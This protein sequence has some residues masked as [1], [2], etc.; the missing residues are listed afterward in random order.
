MRW[1]A[2]SAIWMRYWDGIA[3]PVVQIPT[4]GGKTV[5]ARSFTEQ[6]LND[7]Q[8]FLF[9]VHRARILEQAYEEYAEHFGKEELGIVQA[10]HDAYAMRYVFASWA[11]LNRPERLARYLSKGKPALIITDEAHHV[12]AKSYLRTL[13]Q[14]A[15]PETMTLGIT[16]TPSRA[17][18]TSLKV[19]FQELV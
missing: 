12:P 3:R 13:E 17:D 6:F 14:L 9:L 18:G 16:A 8:R 5:V 4:G 15:G 10:H 1:D 2:L 7:G 19:W 11:S